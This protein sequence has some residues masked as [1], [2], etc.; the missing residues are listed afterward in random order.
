MVINFHDPY[1]TVNVYLPISF[2]VCVRVRVPT[3]ADSL[4]AAAGAGAGRRHA[5][6]RLLGAGQHCQQLQDFRY[7][8]SRMPPPPF[9]I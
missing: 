9:H 8:T 5:G 2:C 7:F 4:P 3:E 6:S 1:C